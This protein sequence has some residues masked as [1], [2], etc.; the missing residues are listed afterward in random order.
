MPEDF[1]N[2]YANKLGVEKLSDE[3]MNNL[4]NNFKNNQ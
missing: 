3:S 1:G 2:Y 4:K